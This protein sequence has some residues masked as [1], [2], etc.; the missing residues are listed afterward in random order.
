MKNK[1]LLVYLPGYE[2]GYGPIFPLGIG[3]LLSAIKQ[4]RPTKAVHYQ[5]MEH[6]IKAL[7]EIVS[8]FSPDIIGLTCSTFNRGNVKKICKWIKTNHPHI[9]IVLGGVHVSFFA[10][11]AIRNYGADYVV[12]GEGE[13]TFKEL[14]HALD[15]QESIEKI[16]GIVYFDGDR[17]ITTESREVIRNLDDILLPDFTYARDIME[18]SGLGFVI[19]S[20]GCPAHCNFCSTSSYWG[21]KVRINSPSRVVDEI[22]I[23]INEYGTKKI[24]FHD[25]TFNLG[26]K[27]VEEICNEILK[28][29]LDITWAASCRVHPVSQEMVDK[30]VEAGCR[31][32]CWG[33]ESGSAEMLTRINKKITQ[34]QIKQAYEYC[35]KY[36]G[37]IS[38]GA[39]TMVGNP[40][41]SE[42]TIKE[43]V[44]FINTLP[45]TDSPSPA[46]LYILPGT[47]IY[48][49]IQKNNPDIDKFWINDDSI[50]RPKEYSGVQL[51]QWAI[52]VGNSGDRIPFDRNHHFF[53]NVLFGN[54]PEPKG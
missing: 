31:H 43:S 34:D 23:M 22:E 27:R 49:D 11:Q 25:D 2:T 5:L 19:T 35:R 38:V 52:R 12:I 53:N 24:L 51:Q 6:A 29:K 28:R 41:E 18:S 3:Y 50:M 54:I 39:F 47:Q 26:I 44:E 7:P 42:K 15:K 16:K 20:R 32:I 10:E 14:C 17:C 45:M 40:G 1:V 30:M 36:I 46:V 4:D 9:K 37:I 33:I 8:S 21:Q 48:K 13:I